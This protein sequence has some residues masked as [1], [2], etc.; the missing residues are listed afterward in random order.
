[1]L[2]VRSED[3]ALYDGGEKS[4]DMLQSA[5]GYIIVSS[6][7][8][9]QNSYIFQVLLFSNWFSNFF[10]YFLIYIFLYSVFLHLLFRVGRYFFRVVI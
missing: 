9:P 2:M 5:S 6:Y 8:V 4:I 3:A 10:S 1:M 7:S